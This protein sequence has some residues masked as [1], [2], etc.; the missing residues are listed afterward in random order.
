MA[1]GGGTFLT[2]NKILPGTYINFVAANRGAVNLSER[3]YV[4]MPLFLNWGPVGEMMEVTAEEFLRN[5]RTLFGREYTHP[6]LRPLRELFS[7]ASVAYLWRLGEE[8][9]A[10]SCRFGVARYPGVLGNAIT[11]A[12]SQTMEGRLLVETFVDGVRVD[13][14]TVFA[15]CDLEDNAFIIFDR[16]VELEPIA[17]I[18]FTG[19]TNSEMVAGEYSRYLEESERFAFNIMACATE[20]TEIKEMFIRHTRRM[21]EDVG[22]KFQCVLSHA[23]SADYEGVISVGTE[24]EEEY[25]GLVYWV[26]GNS[27]GCP[28]NR[29]LTNRRY[30]GEFTVTDWHTHRDLE[31]MLKQGNF[32]FAVGARGD[33]RVVEDV[34]TLQTFDVNRGPDF[35]MNQTIRV[36]DQ[37]ARDIASLFVNRYLGIIPNDNAG[38]LSLWSDIVS[39]HR[40]LEQIRAIEEFEPQD[41]VVEAGETKRAVVVT[42]RITPVNAMSQLYMTVIVQ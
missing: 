23:T 26:A 39:H 4:T 7:G 8:V 15:M 24:A 18:E 11:L 17:G 29:T 10:A 37:V 14:Q 28:I 30:N 25:A 31:Q 22:A 3:G 6:D 19:G 2:Q 41:V 12:I 1:I 34:N 9:E 27:A 38:R 40:Q 5:S 32:M 21:R 42:D 36:L 16:N 13:A 33:V 35:T 20:D